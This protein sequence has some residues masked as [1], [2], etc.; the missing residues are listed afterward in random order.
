[1]Q[2]YDLVLA[3]HIYSLYA[4]GFLMVFYL[5]LTQSSFRT[6]FYFIRRIR[7]FL[8]V[9]YLF[10][11]IVFFTGSLLLALKSFEF[12]FFHGLMLASW[13]LIVALNIFQ[14]NRFKKARQKRRYQGFRAWSFFILL[15]TLFLLTVPYL[16]QRYYAVFIS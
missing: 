10:L 1:M 4:S 7:L 13:C 12:S 15:I 5:F 6:E 2:I 16:Y 3:F 9:Y 8:P 11:S 14:F